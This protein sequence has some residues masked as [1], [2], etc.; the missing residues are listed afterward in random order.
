MAKLLRTKS[1]F[2]FSLD[3]IIEKYLPK[4]F[5]SGIKSTAKFNPFPFT[6]LINF[7]YTTFYIR[8]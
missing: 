8:F 5:D 4:N 7:A 1:C 3:K 6:T 2:I